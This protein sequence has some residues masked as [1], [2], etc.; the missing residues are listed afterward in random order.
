MGELLSGGFIGVADY[1]ITPKNFQLRH[2][3][4]KVIFVI[5][6]LRKND[7][8]IWADYACGV[9]PVLC[10]VSEQKL[11]KLWYSNLLMVV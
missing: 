10:H 4:K 5:F 3:A 7:R 1:A 8:R 9:C 6:S 11:A 2:N